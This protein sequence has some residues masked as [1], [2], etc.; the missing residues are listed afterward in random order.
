M[1]IK[2]NQD[3]TGAW[4]KDSCHDLA[5]DVARGFIAS[6]QAVE[7]DLATFTRASND[8]AFRAFREEM[9]TEV[10]TLAQAK[11]L[12][13]GPPAIKTTPDGKAIIARGIEGSVAAEDRE[14]PT[15]AT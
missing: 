6:N 13:K 12:P 3:I 7:T 5:A 10:R 15:F 14:K 9:L 4:L 11:P 2:F 8:A 1:L